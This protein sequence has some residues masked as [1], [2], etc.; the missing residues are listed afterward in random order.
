MNKHLPT[1][2]GVVLK[3]GSHYYFLRRSERS[4]HW[5]LYWGFPGGKKEEG[6]SLF[7]TAQREL[8]EE[9]G[10]HIDD[11]DIQGSIII[12]ARYIDGERNFVLYLCNSWIGSPENLEKNIHP[13]DG[14]FTL[15]SLPHPILPHI[16][17]GFFRL[18]DGIREIEYDG[19]GDIFE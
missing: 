14:W 4:K 6:E 17:K 7:Q 11:I 13:E 18:L 15:D 5:P 1:S 10:V 3:H 16:E 8:L 2:A 9:T 19:R 12:H